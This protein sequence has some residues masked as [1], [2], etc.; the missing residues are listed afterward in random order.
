LIA[1]LDVGSPPQYPPWRVLR[2]PVSIG[3]GSEGEFSPE[4]GLLLW[5]GFSVFAVWLIARLDLARRRYIRQGGYCGDQ[6]PSDLGLVVEFSP[7]AGLFVLAGLF[8]FRRW[9]IAGLDLARR[10]C[11]RQGGYCGDE[12]PSDLGR[13]IEFLPGGGTQQSAVSLFC[14]HVAGWPPILV[15]G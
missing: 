8:S 13:V 15:V 4:A 6:L 5:R 14:V 2:R 3:P 1:G 10:R 9:L 11:I 7:V 12:F